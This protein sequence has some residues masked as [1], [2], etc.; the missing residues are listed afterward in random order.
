MYAYTHADSQKSQEHSL[1][2]KSG[3]F[4]QPISPDNFMALLQTPWNTQVDMS[5][6]LD[7]EGRWK[8]SPAVLDYAK[9]SEPNRA[10]LASLWSLEEAK[11]SL[12]TF[13]RLDH[14]LEDTNGTSA[15]C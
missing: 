15:C 12:E 1:S 5:L 14:N 7:P 2:L 13:S 11:M 8:S 9:W 3:L 10:Y 6:C 4:D